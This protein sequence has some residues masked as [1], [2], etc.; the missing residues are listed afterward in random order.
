MS[1]KSKKT[2][3]IAEAASWL[4]TIPDEKVGGF[5]TGQVLKDTPEEYVRQN[6]AMSWVASSISARNYARV[7]AATVEAPSRLITG[8]H[9]GPD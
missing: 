4:R 9:A 2:V 1:R 3:N 6:V 8:G 5:I 7:E